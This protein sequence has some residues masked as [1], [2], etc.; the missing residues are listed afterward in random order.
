MKETPEVGTLVK[1]V[2]VFRAHIDM[3]LLNHMGIVRAVYPSFGNRTIV[4][5]EIPT[6]E[7]QGHKL[8]FELL[9]EPKGWFFYPEQLEKV[10]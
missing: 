9:A 1:I 10:V 5:V 4:G 7:N 3:K 6:W 2:K 8:L